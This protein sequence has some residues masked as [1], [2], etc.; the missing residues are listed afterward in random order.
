MTQRLLEG[1][2]RA[3]SITASAPLARGRTHASN[4]SLCRRSAAL[5][6]MTTVSIP[7]WRKH[8]ASRVREESFRSTRAVRAVDFRVTGGGGRTYADVFTMV[9]DNRILKVHSG[10]ASGRL[11][12]HKG[13]TGQYQSVIT[14]DALM[15]IGRYRRLLKRIKEL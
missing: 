13:P 12:E 6:D 9:G 7:N 5:D 14:F 2:L 4:F 10:A 3:A 11:K 8:S 15:E 1:D